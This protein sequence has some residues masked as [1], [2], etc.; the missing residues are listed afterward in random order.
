MPTTDLDPSHDRYLVTGAA[1]FT[2]GYLV[3]HLVDQG[4]PVRAMVRDRSRSADLEALGGVD[5][6]EGD[7]TDP[8]SL[9]VTVEEN[10]DE[11]DANF[12]VTTSS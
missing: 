10:E 11:V 6:V 1:G 7:L 12:A 2:G 4:I 5:L 8:E 9:A 3:R